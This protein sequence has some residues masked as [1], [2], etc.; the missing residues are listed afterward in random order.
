MLASALPGHGLLLTGPWRVHLHVIASKA[1]ERI[2]MTA[3]RER[4]AFAAEVLGGGA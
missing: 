2:A 3:P 1:E 4:Q